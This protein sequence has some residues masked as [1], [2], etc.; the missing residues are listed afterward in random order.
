MRFLR[1]ILLPITLIYAGIIWLRNRF[2]DWGWLKSQKF[3]LP[4]VV[5]GNLAV[6]GTG[7]SPM[8]EYILR[9]VKDQVKIAVL[10]RGYGRKT[11]GF[12][13]VATSDSANLTGDEPLQIKKNFPAVT[14]AVCED[15]CY[16]VAILQQQQDAI[17]LDDAFQH[18]RLSPSFAVLL[19]DYPSLLQPILPLPTGNFRDLMRESRRAQCIVVTKCPTSISEADIEKIKGKLQKY[20]QAPVF[21][22]RIAYCEVQSSTQQMLTADLQTKEVLLLTGIANPKP[23]AIYLEPLTKAM[24]AVH[25]ADHHNFTPTDLKKIAAAYLAIPTTDKCIITTEKD[26]QRLPESF[27]SSYP[28]FYIPI[29]PEILFDQQASFDE[30]IRR[31]CTMHAS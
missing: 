25:Y 2:Y 10:S 12:R 1:W 8:T 3:D 14:V 5:I 28:V 26:Y 20:S 13:Y 17:L 9:L 31:A 30:L 6:G 11:K 16:G 7:K 22:S 18:R 4:I 19:F 29:A 15:R 23:L 27:L 24:T 21:F